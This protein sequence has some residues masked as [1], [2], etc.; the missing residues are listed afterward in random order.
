MAVI[1]VVLV[2]LFL[3]GFFPI[4]IRNCSVSQSAAAA[5]S[6]AQPLP[7]PDDST[8]LS[9]RRSPRCATTSSTR[10]A[11]T[12]GSNPTPPAQSAGPVSAHA[13][14]SIAVEPKTIAPASAS[15]LEAGRVD[16]CTLSEPAAGVCRSSE[17]RP[18]AEAPSE[19][20]WFD[21]FLNRNRESRSHS[22]LM[23]R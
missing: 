12:P 11:S 21:W 6:V 4:Y 7:P 16:G 18:P 10:S 2:A 3:L 14:G 5:A 17:E 8:Q 13:N 20:F 23:N 9:L 1:I 15:D 19:L 22:A